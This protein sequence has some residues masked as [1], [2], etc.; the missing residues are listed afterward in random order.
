MR[1]GW[2][3]DFGNGNRQ[4]A[5]Q[6]LNQWY[7]DYALI[8]DVIRHIARL[9]VAQLVLWLHLWPLLEPSPFFQSSL[10]TAMRVLN[11]SADGSSSQKMRSIRLPGSVPS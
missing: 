9:S 5:T 6:S 2:K 10:V 7:Y 11:P 4:L 3:R 8:S 1:E